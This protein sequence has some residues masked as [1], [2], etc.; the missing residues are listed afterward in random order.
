MK[1]SKGYKILGLLGL[2]FLSGLVFAQPPSGTGSI[3]LRAIGPDGGPLQGTG[4]PGIYIADLD[5]DFFVLANQSGSQEQFTNLPNKPLLF[6]AVIDVPGFGKLEF[7]ASNNGQGYTPS[8]QTLD[9]LYEVA[10][11]R[12]LTAKKV[13]DDSISQGF[14]FDSATVNS[15]AQA[16]SF[17]DSAS[18]SLPG[19]KEQA[20]FSLQSLE[21]SA[22]TSEDIVVQKAKQKIQRNGGFSSDK[23]ISTFAAPGFPE[24]KPWYTVTAPLINLGIFDW[25]WRWTM[26]QDCTSFD[27]SDSWHQLDLMKRF[28]DDGKKIRATDGIWLNGL[29]PLCPTFQKTKQN[30]VNTEVNYTKQLLQRFPRIDYLPILSEPHSWG[31]L[32]G[33]FSA[34][35][36]A[37][38]TKDAGD[39]IHALSPQSDTLINLVLPWGEDAANHLHDNVSV[40]SPYKFSQMVNQLGG[41]YDDIVLQFYALNKDIFE[42]D[43]ILE[44]YS[45]L[46]KKILLELGAPSA[47]PTNPSW[48]SNPWRGGWTETTQA[49]WLN[50]FALISLSKDS[51]KEFDWWD[52]AE[53][54]SRFNFIVGNPPYG[55]VNENYIPKESYYTLAKLIYDY[56]AR[57]QGL[58][59]NFLVSQYNFENN[60]TDSEGIN[61]GI[62][63]NV[64]FV[65][66]TTGKG[67]SFNGVDSYIEGTSPGVN[68]PFWDSDRTISASVKISNANGIDRGIFQYGSG[69]NA[70]NS[71]HLYLAKNGNFAAGNCCGYGIVDSGVK[72]DDNAWHQVMVLYNKSTNILTTYVDGIKRNSATLSSR[73]NTGGG[74][75]LKWSIGSFFVGSS[76][77]NGVIDDLKIWNYAITPFPS[78][79]PTISSFSANPAIINSGQSSTLSWSVTGATSLSITPGIGTVNGN[80]IQVTPNQTTTYTLTATNSN[81]Y[82]T[83]KVIVSVNS[84]PCA[85]VTCISPATAYC[86]GST[87]IYYASTGTCNTQTGTC[88]YTTTSTTC[89]YGCANGTCLNRITQKV[90]SVSVKHEPETDDVFIITATASDSSGIKRI[91]LFVDNDKKLSCMNSKCVSESKYSEGFHNYYAVAVN[92]ANYSASTATYTFTVNGIQQPSLNYSEQ[93][94]Q[95]T[96][97]EIKIITKLLT[98]KDIMNSIENIT[99]VSGANYA[100]YYDVIG[101]RKGKILWLIPVRV[102]VHVYMDTTTF[103]I[104]SMQAPFWNIFVI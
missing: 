80:S 50:D 82:I 85:G 25:E 70:P 74:V 97:D 78:Q 96:T 91:D 75:K 8:D 102:P 46:G 59:R 86:S 88:S 34:E 44:K 24:G 41:R 22:P 62:G 26:L 42:I 79:L 2:I 51:V 52:L 47:V 38:I 10:R 6:N 58:K 95:P 32:G 45:Q 103:Q 49:K 104:S 21:I 98:S 61:D 66:G 55:V 39:G 12:Y 101:W 15:M 30:V 77:V 89:Q 81:G 83:K 37:Q 53:V 19:S 100:P 76:P 28:Q 43:Q 87:K 56:G 36:L 71:F 4:V 68:L 40:V 3:T 84:D 7:S 72:I 99:I 60:F 67:A 93:A 92:K 94:K 54:G 57:L 64:I 18:G 5:Y 73:P 17:L 11:S 1:I 9:V 31:N 20:S 27:W 90:P 48:P 33:T 35:D 16:K 23:L 14:S 69:E 13:M 29:P 63:H 65:N